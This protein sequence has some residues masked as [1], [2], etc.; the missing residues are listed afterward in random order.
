MEVATIL[1]L[2][3]PLRGRQYFREGRERLP[4]RGLQGIGEGDKLGMV[5]ICLRRREEGGDGN[6]RCRP[7]GTWE[8]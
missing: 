7:P 1:F 8:A 3:L 5:G 6:N 4:W 2:I